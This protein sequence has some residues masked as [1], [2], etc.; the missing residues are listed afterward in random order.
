MG[1]NDW[2]LVM[3]PLGFRT[4]EPKPSKED[5]SRYYAER[6]YQEGKGSYEVTYTPQEIE[7]H[8]LKARLIRRQVERTVALPPGARFLDIGCGEGRLLDQFASA[9]YDA[10]GVD[11]SDHGITKWHPQMVG[12]MHLGD[13]E[14]FLGGC[15]EA[16]QTYDVVAFT[17]VVEHVLDPRRLVSLAK[18]VVARGGVMVIVA[19]NDFSP[20]HEKLLSEGIISEP[21]WIAYPDHLSYFNKDSMLRCWVRRVSR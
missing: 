7:H 11:F 18:A 17:N 15:V 13:Y 9:G 3:D 12:R 5:L 21:F 6:Y 19:P 4:I 16:R 2:E 14:E 8:R 10:T 20:L 1:E